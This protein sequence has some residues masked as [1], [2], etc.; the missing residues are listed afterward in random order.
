M[1]KNYV[2]LCLFILFLF[3]IFSYQCEAQYQNFGQNGWRSGSKGTQ[4]TNIQMLVRELR[5]IK[6][7]TS[8]L[9]LQQ[10]KQLLLKV[11]KRIDEEL[12]I[13]D[14][15]IEYKLS[16]I[17][18]SKMLRPLAG[19]ALSAIHRLKKMKRNRAA[20]LVSPPNEP[21]VS[22]A[23]TRFLGKFWLPDGIDGMIIDSKYAYVAARRQ[24]FIILDISEPQMV[25]KVGQLKLDF[26]N[27]VIVKGNYCFIAGGQRRFSHG[28]FSVVDISRK[29]APMLIEKFDLPRG[30]N[31]IYDYKQYVFVSA[32]G[33]GL[34]IYDCSNP[35]E[36][37]F[38]SNFR[39]QYSPQEY[40]LVAKETLL[41]NHTWGVKV[42][43]K[44][45]YVCDDH[46]G[47]RLV[48]ISDI[49]RPR[50]I[51]RFIYKKGLS[52]FCNDVVVDENY[53]Y[54]AYDFGY[55]L[56]VD[57]SNKM[58]P[59]I[60]GMFNP[61]G[62]KSWKQSDFVAIRLA[63]AKD[64]IYVATSRHGGVAVI[65]VKNPKNP[66]KVYFYEGNASVWGLVV[67]NGN[68]YCGEMPIEG[69]RWGGLEIFT[70]N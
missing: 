30:A 22:T 58:R 14:Q 51:S 1:K 10:Q 17:K 25:S 20:G 40:P 70:Q 29:E 12:D 4:R 41:E 26:V 31:R 5:K 60:V 37:K 27:D 21:F 23:K 24:G 50:Q 36:P 38:M 18:N 55:L 57:I 43:N 3:Q 47:I 48:D 54:L 34:F 19:K 6:D 45:A 69:H 65:D 66:R 28:H 61:N 2:Y 63:K 44:I 62:N 8:T 11:V 68:I 59:K 33:A 35:R 9:S 52:G 53:M 15:A 49:R 64:L 32:H 46:A 39:M 67:T 16:G 13:A 7:G 42:R 56:I